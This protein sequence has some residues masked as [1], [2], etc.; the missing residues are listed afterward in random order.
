MG[1]VNK[2]LN[3]EKSTDIFILAIGAVRTRQTSG[4][5]SLMAKL[6]GSEQRKISFSVR[7]VDKWNRLPEEIK[8]TAPQK[9]FRKTLKNFKQ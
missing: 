3:D 7:T 5:K 1:L 8:Q 2:L 4:T 6:A 9:D